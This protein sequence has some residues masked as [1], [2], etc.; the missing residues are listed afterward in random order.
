MNAPLLTGKEERW[1]GR[2]GSEVDGGLCVD[3]ATD[4]EADALSDER[5]QN[6]HLK[7]DRWRFKS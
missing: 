5:R 3:G 7:K 2:D 1:D 4:D 6:A